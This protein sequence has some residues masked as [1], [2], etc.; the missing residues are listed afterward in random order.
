M[1]YD[2]EVCD[3]ALRERVLGPAMLLENVHLVHAHGAAATAHTEQDM[4]EL[5]DA[6]RKVAR[7]VKPYV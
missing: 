3:V 4:E 6:C 2:P 5:E 7:R 1:V